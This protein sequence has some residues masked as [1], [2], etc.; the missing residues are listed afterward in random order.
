MA[1]RLLFL[2]VLPIGVTLWYMIALPGHSFQG[3]PAPLTA[4]GQAL[5]E[6]LRG[7]VVAIASVEHNTGEPQALAQASSYLE[8][9][10]RAMGYAVGVQSYDSGDGEVRNLEVEIK[11][12]AT[13]D[14]IVVVGAHYDS[15]YS[16]PGANDNGSGTA[17]VLELA[18]AFQGSRPRKTVRFVL[19]ANEEPPYFGAGS[20]GSM[21]YARRSRERGD[22][23]IGMLSLE[24]VGYYDD[25]AGSQ[26]YPNIF[27]PFFPDTGNFIAFIGDLKSRDLLHRSIGHFRAAQQF[28]S[29]G[30]AT[31]PWIKGINWSDHSAFWAH[32]YRALMITDT[33]IFRYPHYHTRQDTPDKLDYTRMA[34]LLGGIYAVVGDLAEAPNTAN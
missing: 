3:P 33:A 7:H 25:A 27:K 17:M 21:V 22:N 20:M 6:R 15:A 1:M 18:R 5:A 23:I 29:E 12:T 16:A 28:P 24:T 11:G 31:F 14:Q 32:D 30:I 19:F 26:K 13:P 2:I 4:A 8:A 9:Q 10:L 34:R